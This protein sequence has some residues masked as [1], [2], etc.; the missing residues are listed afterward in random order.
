MG[1]VET[2]QQPAPVRVVT[3]AAYEAAWAAEMIGRIVEPTVR[4]SI[5][6]PWAAIVLASTT[7]TSA[8]LLSKWL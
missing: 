8:S 4:A 7:S 3:G 5:S 1:D 2:H 6:A